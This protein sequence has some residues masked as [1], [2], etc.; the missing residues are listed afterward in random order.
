MTEDLGQSP[1]SVEQPA[2]APAP[3]AAP[4]PAPA[5]QQPVIRIVTDQKSGNKKVKRAGGAVIRTIIWIIVIVV[6]LL[7]AL[8]ASAWIAGFTNA[9]GYPI[10]FNDGE[11]QGMI[12]WIRSAIR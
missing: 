6:V 12:D 3:A 4:A 5:P 10:L 7:L 11:Y 9:N 1:Q 8:F 2:P